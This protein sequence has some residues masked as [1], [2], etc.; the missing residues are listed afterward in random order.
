MGDTH[1]SLGMLMAFCCYYLW[2]IVCWLIIILVY[3]AISKLL[4]SDYKKAQNYNND[5]INI[6][7]HNNIITKVPTIQRLQYYPLIF[8][9]CWFWEILS[10]SYNYLNEENLFIIKCLQIFFTNLY[11]LFNA[12][13]FFFVIHHYTAN[14]VI[15][16][17]P[18]TSNQKLKTSKQHSSKTNVSNESIDGVLVTVTTNTNC[19]NKCDEVSGT[20]VSLNIGMIEVVSP[21]SVSTPDRVFS[22]DF[23]L[24]FD[25]QIDGVTDDANISDFDNGNIRVIEEEESAKDVICGWKDEIINSMNQTKMSLVRETNGTCFSLLRNESDVRDIDQKDLRNIL[26]RNSNSKS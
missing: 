24:K 7:N 16:K 11:G 19:I 13:L 4:I 1:S 5:A 3:I 6:Q 25:E 21:S 14:H 8:I 15:Y 23:D 17:Q 10:I 20:T 18:K 12:L 2:L 9:F 26:H 22:H